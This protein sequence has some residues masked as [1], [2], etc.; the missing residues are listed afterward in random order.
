MAWH[1]VK[2]TQIAHL[3]FLLG[4]QRLPF[5][6]WLLTMEISKKKKK[7]KNKKERTVLITVSFK[8]LCRNTKVIELSLRFPYRIF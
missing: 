6:L 8:C 1:P 4:N 5:N 3:D 7:K 2:G